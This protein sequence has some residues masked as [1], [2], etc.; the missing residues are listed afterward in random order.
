MHVGLHHLISKCFV[1]GSVVSQSA[2][3][4]M[5]L[6]LRV[7]S[8]A[9]LLVEAGKVLWE[10]DVFRQEKAG[11]L[12][13]LIYAPT[14]GTAPYPSTHQLAGHSSIPGSPLQSYTDFLTCKPNRQANST[15]QAAMV[16]PLSLRLTTCCLC[17]FPL[18][19]CFLTVLESVQGTSR[20]RPVHGMCVSDQRRMQTQCE[21]GMHTLTLWQY[22][23]QQNVC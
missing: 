2:N 21:D 10:L 9:E 12:P 20:Q 5:K 22:V 13:L 1:Q 23:R 19:H 7:R 16:S 15:V 3:A 18:L 8:S 4:Y 11:K 17:K 14:A 6:S